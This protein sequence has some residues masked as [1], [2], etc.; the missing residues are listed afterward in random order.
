MMTI[1]SDL[2]YF[3]SCASYF[4]CDCQ[5]PIQSRYQFGFKPKYLTGFKKRHG[6]LQKQTNV[7]WSSL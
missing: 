1:L 5:T 6:L 3:M 2:N 4:I 7:E